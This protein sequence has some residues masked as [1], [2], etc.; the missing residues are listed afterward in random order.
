MQVDRA[1]NA[2]TWGGI[3]EG[4]ILASRLGLRIRFLEKVQEGWLELATDEGAHV[5][6]DIAVVWNGT[7]FSIADMGNRSG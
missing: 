6:H 2:S 3:I 1:D 4:K 7:H 5:C